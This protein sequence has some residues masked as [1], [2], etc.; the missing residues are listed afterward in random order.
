MNSSV[1]SDPRSLKIMRLSSIVS[2]K[3]R[4]VIGSAQTARKTDQEDAEENLEWILSMMPLLANYDK[5]KKKRYAASRGYSRAAA[6]NIV[7]I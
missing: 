7:D 6:S 3:N 5:E 4:S 2:S 1:I